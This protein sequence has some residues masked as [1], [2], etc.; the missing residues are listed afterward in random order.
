MQFSADLHISLIEEKP[1]CPYFPW[2]ISAFLA[3][4]TA[5]S[6]YNVKQG[7]TLQLRN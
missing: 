6:S 7:I 4:I 2:D 1:G 3:N 5:Y